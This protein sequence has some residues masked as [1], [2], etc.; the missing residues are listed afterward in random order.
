MRRT[1]LGFL[2]LIGLAVCSVACAQGERPPAAGPGFTFDRSAKRPTVE[3]VDPDSPASEMGLQPGDVVI[4]VDGKKVKSM[5]DFVAAF[6]AHGPW[7][8]GDVLR[9]RIRRGGKKLRVE[10]PLRAAARTV[11]HRPAPPLA[12][13]RWGRLP[14]GSDEPPTL[15][16]LKGKVVVL[17]AFSP[18]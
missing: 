1:V 16:S 11:E 5:E 4:E 15:E 14:E 18:T 2:P 17:L 7:Y 10:A 8:A 13:S 9:M 12:F 6:K 3:K